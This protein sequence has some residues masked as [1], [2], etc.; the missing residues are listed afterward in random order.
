MA[1]KQRLA[2]ERENY[3]VPGEAYERF[4]AQGKE[5]HINTQ[6]E[7]EEHLE[8]QKIKKVSLPPAANR[9]RELF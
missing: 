3:I 1:S 9:A 4:D 8:N 7:R 2:R 6:K 5:D